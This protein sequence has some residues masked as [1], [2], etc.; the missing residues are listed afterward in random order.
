MDHITLSKNNEKIEATAEIHE[1]K[2]GKPHTNRLD[3]F[4]GNNRFW[5]ERLLTTPFWRNHLA[6]CELDDR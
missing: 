1:T 6:A 4:S 2:S 3:F 5:V